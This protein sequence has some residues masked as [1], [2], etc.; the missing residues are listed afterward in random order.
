MKLNLFQLILRQSYQ[1]LPAAL[2]RFHEARLGHF[3]GKAFVKGAGG[4]FAKLLRKLNGFPAPS[5]EELPVVVKVIRS[6]SEERWL[7]KFGTTQFSSTMT[8]INSENVLVEDF[9]LFRFKFSLG[10]RGEQIHWTLVGWNFAGIP[11]L[12]AL[13]PEIT[14]WE[15]VDANGNYQFSTVVK[16][17]LV[18]VLVDYSGWLDCK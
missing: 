4:G 3:E 12:D 16:F 18:G 6:E 17:P 14:A 2:H 9:G 11:M 8:R 5:A 10:V 7:R 13:G 15:G 1:T